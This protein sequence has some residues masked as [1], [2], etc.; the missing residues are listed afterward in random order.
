MQRCCY[1]EAE[2]IVSSAA[3]SRVG[4]WR[5]SKMGKPPVQIYDDMSSE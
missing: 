5:N 2:N 3:G 4:S 1:L